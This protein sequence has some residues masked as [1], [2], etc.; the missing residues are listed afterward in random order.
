MVKELKALVPVGEK[1]LAEA[2][3]AVKP[4]LAQ[5]EKLIARDENGK[6]AADDLTVEGLDKRRL[7][8]D[9]A[10]AVVNHRKQALALL[11]DATTHTE[12]AER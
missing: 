1:L 9:A 10:R 7:E 5:W 6:S 2:E 12:F 11:Q 3:E 4:L 8:V